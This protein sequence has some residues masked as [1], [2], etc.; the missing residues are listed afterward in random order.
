MLLNSDAELR[1][2]AIDALVS[3]MDGLPRAGLATARLVSPD[4]TPQN[5]AQRSPS[6]FRTLLEASRLHKLIP[7]PARGRILLGPYWTY[8][9]AIQVGWTWGTALIARRKAVVDN[10]PLS[11]DFFMYGEDLEWCLRMRKH[12]W[13]VWY[14]PDAEVLHHGGHS[15][16]HKWDD[17]ERLTSKF[18]GIYKAI[19]K[20]RGRRYVRALQ[21][22]SFVALSAERLASRLGRRQGDRLAGPLDYYRRA[23]TGTTE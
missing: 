9:E 16:V 10:G 6:I 15:T 4:G 12:G 1:M 11:E 3:F 5:C 21:A 17:T 22:A 2:G 20:Y 18:N 13:Q 19:E 7:T 8:D 14:C 23:L